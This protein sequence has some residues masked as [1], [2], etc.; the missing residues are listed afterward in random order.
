MFLH[1]KRNSLPRPN[2]QLLLKKFFFI[3]VKASVLFKKRN[4]LKVPRS[5]SEII[6][7]FFFEISSR[8][9]KFR[10][11]GMR[12]T[13]RNRTTVANRNPFLRSTNTN[14][15]L[16]QKKKKIS[17]WEKIKRKKKTFKMQ[18]KEEQKSKNRE[19]KKLTGV[20]KARKPTETNR[21]CCISLM[22]PQRR[23]ISKT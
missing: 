9:K 2:N 11:K 21:V 14:H 8:Q 7:F 20:R 15:V 17:P 19:E 1:T 4:K 10:G 6:C 16:S 18:V 3:T 23:N 12:T 22:I 13:D 5:Q